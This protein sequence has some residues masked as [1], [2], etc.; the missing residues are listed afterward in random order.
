VLGVR[1]IP[2][3]V[4]QWVLRRNS[5]GL[6]V[7]VPGRADNK[8]AAKHFVSSVGRC[9]I[10]SLGDPIGDGFGYVFG[11]NEADGMKRSSSAHADDFADA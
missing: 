6:A 8:L 2:G 11:C 7:E 3:Y 10:V 5:S 9:E 1:T 4:F